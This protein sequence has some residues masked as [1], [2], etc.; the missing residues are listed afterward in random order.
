MH[1]WMEWSYTV[2]QTEV[3]VSFR[4][5]NRI[6]CVCVRFIQYCPGIG[7]VGWPIR[8]L[9]QGFRLFYHSVSSTLSFNMSF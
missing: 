8:V 5:P 4:K 9:N 7:D 1:W 2:T 6:I 3:N